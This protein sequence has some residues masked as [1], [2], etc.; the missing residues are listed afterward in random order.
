MKCKSD[1]K[2]WQILV[3][4]AG[5]DDSLWWDLLSDVLVHLTGELASTNMKGSVIASLNLEGADKFVKGFNNDVFKE[6]NVGMREGS[7]G[8]NL[9]TSNYSSYDAFPT[10]FHLKRTL[11]CCIAILRMQSSPPSTPGLL[12]AKIHSE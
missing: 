5:D 11:I 8:N 2:K 9:W 12:N 7:V 1:R 10:H 4:E 3:K 6:W